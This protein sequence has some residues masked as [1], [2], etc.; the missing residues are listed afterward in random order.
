MG[1]ESDTSGNV[2]MINLWN[3]VRDKK[4]VMPEKN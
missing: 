1:T 2:V 4:M 3:M